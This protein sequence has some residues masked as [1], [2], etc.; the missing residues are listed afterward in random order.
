MKKE[1][2]KCIVKP[3]YDGLSEGKVLGRKCVECG[4][5]EFPPHI[6]CNSCGHLETE[7][8][9]LTHAKAMATQVIPGCAAFIWPSVAEMLGDFVYIA[10]QIEGCDEWSS[11]L[12]GV[13]NDQVDE[14]SKQLPLP[15]KP[16][17]VQDD[18]F[19]NLF[20]QL[21]K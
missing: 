10:V 11:A 14:L 18:G 17:F 12:V 1:D 5:V 7:W 6:A 13:S 8:V 21:D 15:V 3:Y 19:T 16:Y 9:D 2:I 20:W 4:H